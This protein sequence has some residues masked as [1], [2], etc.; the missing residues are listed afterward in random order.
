MSMDRALIMGLRLMKTK[1]GRDE[2]VGLHNTRTNQIN[3]I[4]SAYA[5]NVLKS[6]LFDSNYKK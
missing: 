2:K 1:Q 5:V 4:Y 6:Q 3:M